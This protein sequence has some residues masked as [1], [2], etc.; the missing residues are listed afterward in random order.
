MPYNIKT[1]DRVREHLAQVPGITI[2][3]KKMFSGLAFMVNG[4]MCVNVTDDNLMC[5]FDPVLTD[6]LADKRGF[7]PMIMRGTVYQ[8]YCYVEPEGFKSKKDFEYW[9][10]MCLDFNERAKPAKKRKQP[11]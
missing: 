11:L 8:G 7:L 5:R 4:K 9:I 10:N 6:T 1:A 2:E 3:E